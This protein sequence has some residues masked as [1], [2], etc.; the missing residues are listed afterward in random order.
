MESSI[1][2][3]YVQMI[4]NSQQFIYI[5]NQYFYGSAYSWLEKSDVN[6]H[7]TIPSEIAQKIVEKIHAN[8]RFTAYIVIPMFPNGNPASTHVQEILF[9]QHKTMEM[10]YGRVA[11]AI[12]QTGSNSHPTDWLLFLCLGKR[13]P[14]GPHLNKLE[15]PVEPMARIFRKSLRFPIYVHSKM[16]IVDDAYIILGSA[17]INERSLSG[18]RDT[19]MAV[20][21]WQ[22]SFNGSNPNGDVQRFRMSLWTEHF[23]YYHPIL[24]CPGSIE[25]VQKVK[26][27][28]YHNW[29]M[30]VGPI[31]STT[32]GH[33]LCY[34]I[35]VMADGSLKN[36]PETSSF[37]DFPQG[38][39][40]IGSI[41][42]FIPRK[43][44]T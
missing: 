14:D 24:N 27:M 35:N 34:P 42:S 17:N 18:S 33:L 39:K 36:L 7:H 20:G 43:L 10:M 13:E 25:C 44:T 9:Y 37:P 29:Q 32:P 3:A 31:G 30:Y 5:E 4:R 16:M 15:A 22:P 11:E 19:E 26:E 12:K 23:R 6:C 21:C 40:I 28:A 8:Q 2:Q 38:S 41:S 1:A